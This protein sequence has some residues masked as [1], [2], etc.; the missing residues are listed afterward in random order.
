MWHCEE[1]QCCSVLQ[2]LVT[3]DISSSQI[4]SIEL[5]FRR[6]VLQPL[7]TA[8][9][10]P[11]SLILSIELLFGRSVLQPLVTVKVVPSLFIHPDDGNDALLR[12][13]SPS[14]AK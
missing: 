6:S 12:N 1:L 11:S 2:P 9:V 13:V 14:R 7:V 3:A 5:L 8:K 4:L 10:V